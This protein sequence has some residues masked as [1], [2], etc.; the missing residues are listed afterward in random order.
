MENMSARD[1]HSRLLARSLEYNRTPNKMRRA[2]KMPLHNWELCVAKIL[3]T[4]RHPNG[5]NS[6]VHW[7]EDE[8]V[9]L[10]LPANCWHLGHVGRKWRWRCGRGWKGKY[11]K[12]DGKMEL[13]NEHI[14]NGTWRTYGVM[15]SSERTMLRPTKIVSH[16]DFVPPF[17]NAWN[18][19]ASAYRCQHA[20]AELERLAWKIEIK[21]KTK[22]AAKNKL[23]VADCKSPHIRVVLILKM[24]ET[25]SA[26]MILESRKEYFDSSCLMVPSVLDSKHIRIVSFHNFLLEFKS[27]ISM[28][29]SS[30]HLHSIHFWTRDPTR[31][32][33]FHS[34]SVWNGY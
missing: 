14:E 27:N 2:L 10:P 12:M 32:D 28:D 3:T 31:S 22:N 25:T 8:C 4:R 34:K 26:R 21:I 30:D 7:D 16:I 13:W 33:D 19:G 18:A 15:H 29:R 1:S 23:W 5:M 11:T 9:L 6:R 17:M 24:I 20:I